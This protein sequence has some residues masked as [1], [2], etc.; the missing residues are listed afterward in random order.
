MQLHP[1]TP[2]A[3]FD[4]GGAAGA[5]LG[6]DAS[7]VGDAGGDGAEGD[8]VGLGLGGDDAGEGGLAAA[9]RAPEDDRG[10]LAG[11]DEAP[12]ELATADEVLLADV[13]VEGAR[14]HAGGERGGGVV[15]VVEGGDAFRL[16]ERGLGG[17]A[18]SS[19]CTWH[20]AT[21]VASAS[22]ARVTA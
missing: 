8:E 16:E 10:E 3:W 6:D 18:R 4:E 1:C 9:G 21:I 17:L 22:K 2:L 11:V 7:E 15:R 12:E 19:R 13:L 14:P 5:G 20:D